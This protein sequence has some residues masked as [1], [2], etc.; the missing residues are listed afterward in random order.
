MTERNEAAAASELTSSRLLSEGKADVARV[1]ER[2]LRRRLLRALLLVVVVGGY[3]DLRAWRHQSILPHLPP[4]ADIWLPMVLWV[5]MMLLLGAFVLLPMTAGRS[6]H[7]VIRPEEIEI[8]L[9]GVRGLDGQVDEVMR[10]LDVFLGYRTFR[11]VLG[12]NPRRGVLFEGPPG[13]GKT[14]LAKAMAKQAG[15]PFM[16]VSASEFQTMWYGMT[17]MRIRRFFRRLR[18]LAARE[19]G[20]IG[21]IEELDAIGGNR[22]GVAGTPGVPAAGL[23]ARAVAPFLATD[24]SGIVNELLVQMQSFDEQGRGRRAWGRLVEWVNGYLPA[25]WRLSTPGGAYHNV[26][27]VAATNRAS[28]LDP[29][30]LR[31]GRFDRKL[32]FDL[33]TKRARRELVDFFLERK[34]HEP[35]LDPDEVRERLAHDTL[36]STPAMIEHLFDEALVVALRKGRRAMEVADVYDARLTEEIGLK[37]PVTYTEDE[38]RAIAV[39]ESGH[40]TVAHLLGTGR[41][42][43]VLSIIKRRESLGLLAHAETEERFTR[44]RSELEVSMAIALGGMVAEELFLG[45]STT[46]PGGDLAQATAV[47]ATMVGALGMGGSLLSFEAVDSGML[48]QNLVSK[49]MA[50]RDAK[51]QA[52]ALLKAQKVRAR[53]VLAANRD[54]VEALRDALVAR[55]ELVGDEILTV[56]RDTLARREAVPDA[57]TGDDDAVVVLPDVETSVE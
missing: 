19:G 33:P 37:Q 12:G 16:F 51:R 17:N 5:L 38:R 29:A 49:V 46:G 18:R 53:A 36:G 44:T 13:T 1:R 6:P 50:D 20:A 11:E 7:R 2:K 15:V 42:L 4:N 25:E 45:E 47:A 26:L 21:F 3:V 41:R 55:D 39:H 30:L 56:I 52:D 34:A 28:A 10:T 57:S 48:Q 35:E 9:D 23:G 27:V 14:Y 43:E 22:G 32:Y 31:P 24:T 40:A 8:G 54:V